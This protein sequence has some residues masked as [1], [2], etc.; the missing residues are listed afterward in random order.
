MNIPD[1]DDNMNTPP[2]GSPVVPPTQ[3]DPPVTPPAQAPIPPATPNTGPLDALGAWFANLG[4]GKDKVQQPTQA[5]PTQTPPVLIPV[6]PRTSME[7]MQDTIAEYD[8]DYRNMGERMLGFFQQFAGYVVPF[9]MVVAVGNDLGSY[10]APFLGNFS[11]YLIAFAM[12]VTI[13]ALTIAMGRAFEQ[14]SS[15]K[16]D[17]TKLAM[18]VGGWFLLNASTAFGLYQLASA[19]PINNTPVGHISLIIRVTAIALV[20]LGCSFV[21]MWRGKSLQKHIE[22]IRKRATAMGELADARR[23]IE[24]ADKNA[25][26]R[27]QMMKATLKIQDDMSK[28]IGK[29]VE[30]VM[31]SILAKMEA[32]LKDDDTK[33]ERGY[34]RR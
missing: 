7:K 19:A 5:G 21:L 26:L 3:P 13:A 25:A 34:G 4:K 16:A 30:M 31:E 24:E 20:D 22:S 9:V 33:N 18:T 14:I 8:E 23:A 1:D 27:E 32:S 17:W 15:G 29:G 6:K 10:F 11:A 12:E 28:Q 2:N